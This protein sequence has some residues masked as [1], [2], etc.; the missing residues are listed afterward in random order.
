MLNV[1]DDSLVVEEKGI[2]SVEKFIVARRLMYWQVYLHKTGIVAEKLLVKIMKRAKELT[3]QGVALPAS[4]ALS[5]FLSHTIR[6]ENFT[7]ETL[8]MF[9]TLDDYDII[10]SLKQWTK[11][12]DFVLRTLC[13]DL[14]DRKLLRIEIE[15][16][17]IA[18]DRVEVHLNK[19]MATYNLTAHEASYFV[20]SGSI[21]N[22]AYRSDKNAINLLTKSGVVVDVAK[23]SDQLNI[24]ALSVE[25][26]KYYLCY[27][28]AL[29]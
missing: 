14:L 7:K 21:S 11:Q 26:I 22:R 16:N 2:Y 17:P 15:N 6:S 25:V 29:D 23:A 24:S 5:F 27:P 13:Q 9:S 1:V 8:D 18:L 3:M 28:K 20:F 19:M 12:D 10:F 4:T